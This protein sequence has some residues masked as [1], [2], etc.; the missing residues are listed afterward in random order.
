M[1]LIILISLAICLILG[2]ASVTLL[3]FVGAALAN[4]ADKILEIQNKNSDELTERLVSLENNFAKLI[5]EINAR[6][7]RRTYGDDDVFSD[8]PRLQ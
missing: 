6:L 8:D 4:I 5:Y 2:I 7:P 3:I 1:S